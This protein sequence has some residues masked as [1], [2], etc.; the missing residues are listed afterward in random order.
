MGSYMP[1]Q[2]SPQEVNSA[3]KGAGWGGNIHKGNFRG[4]S[5]PWITH[6]CAGRWGQQLAQYIQLAQGLICKMYLMFKTQ[7]PTPRHRGPLHTAVSSCI[8][9]PSLQEIRESYRAPE[10][11]AM[12]TLEGPGYNHQ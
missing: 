8:P 1:G 4:S 12:G 9:T 2:L 5:L 6:R 3:D 7:P 10:R 11:C